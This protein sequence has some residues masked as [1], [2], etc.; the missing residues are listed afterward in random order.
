MQTFSI[1]KTLIKRP[2]TVMILFFVLFA[3]SVLMTGWIHFE[4]DIFEAFPQDSPELRILVHTLKT[5]TAQDKLYLLVTGPKDTQKLLEAGRQLCRELTRI[6]MKDRPAFKT[7]TLQKTGALS[8]EDFRS[9]MTRFFKR[10]ETFLATKDLPRLQE[11][12][13]S[14][15]ALEE[16]IRRSLAM[17]A[18]PGSQS[19]S[20][21]ISIDPLNL[22]EFVMEKLQAM[23]QGLEFRPGPNLLSPD[24]KA[25][26]VIAS[27]APT[28]MA[29]ASA[30]RLLQKIDHIRRGHSD[31]D[32][33]VTGGYAIAAQ[34]EALVK[35]DI[36]WC[37]AGS[38]LAIGLLFHLIY[39]NPVA[40]VFVLLP[41]GVGL[42][43]ALGIISLAFHQIHLLATAFAT[44]VLGLGI[45][46]AVHVYD[47]YAMERQAGRTLEEA[48]NRSV[49][50]TGS[51]VLAGCLTTLAAFLVLTMTQ[52]PILH[53]I[54]WLVSL[55]LLC[56]LVTILI[57]LPACLVWLEQ[58]LKR[59]P[60]HS[61]RLLGADRLGAAVL[62][63]PKTWGLISLAI[64]FAATPGIFRLRFETDPNSLRPQGLEAVDVQE[65]LLTAFGADRHYV[66]AS[67]TAEDMDS[68]W[69]KGE[70]VDKTL[71]RLKD[72]GMVGSWSSLTQTGSKGPL[73]IRGVDIE[74]IAGLFSK[75]G[76]TLDQ[77]PETRRFL[78]AV[79]ENKKR[80][81]PLSDAAGQ[82]GADSA[83]ASL[84]GLP[85]LLKR[86]YVCEDG[87]V[88]GITYITVSGETHVPMIRRELT[89]S[90]PKLVVISPK[91]AI[92]GLVSEVRKELKTTVTVT[93]V[94]IIGILLLFFRRPKP[95]A[96]VLMPV[97]M[98]VLVTSGVMGWAQ[99]H[100]NPFNFIVIPILIGIGLDD[101]IHIFKRYEEIADMGETLSTTGRSVLVTSL[102]TVAGFGSL[103]MADY[104]VL[105]SM[106]V[107]A[108]VGVLACFF[109]SV[110][111]LPAVIQL[112]NSKKRR[113]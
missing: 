41:L 88:R 42:Q 106:G 73:P 60:R 78:Q 62:A 24:G 14:E 85:E 32:I 36:L 56:C 81:N 84:N 33:G 27:P 30:G 89:K 54:G 17:L 75:Y 66:L 53:Q 103:S 25:L 79:A 16:R 7:V 45:D 69:K 102:T 74:G 37:I 22:R 20:R 44:V 86:F 109:F 57:A 47:R 107:M 1:A 55:G 105:Q 4:Q 46:F 23:H 40:L 48:V 76:L 71:S 18:A 101:G 82:E 8:E 64:L 99:I 92:Q 49:I 6:R 61:M 83:C 113:G 28:A 15:S 80:S 9:L 87:I 58:R 10:P 98:G 90:F 5:S 11:I 93:C 68:F 100:L 26:L 63:H 77:F 31:L 21:V 35:D 3:A 59:P 50:N 96:F 67:W 111:T 43:L 104:H 97:F 94:L 2:G 65:N 72:D 112:R 91:S 19:M 95:L 52:S 51:A 110:I 38:I 13:T 12:L 108:I 70:D 34:E 29:P 39:R